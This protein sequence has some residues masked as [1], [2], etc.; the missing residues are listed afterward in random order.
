MT[1]RT[2]PATV[3]LTGMTE[4]GSEISLPISVT[5]SNLPNAP[6][7]PP[8]IHALAARTI[9][10][11]LEDGQHDIAIEDPDLLARTVKA[12]IVRLGKTFSLSSSETSFVAVDDSESPASTSKR[13]RHPDVVQIPMTGNII[14]TARRAC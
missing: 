9:I 3:T 14:V 13:V 4:D 5:L 10:Q 6:E 2:V 1:G 12:S 7:A 8:A 11:D